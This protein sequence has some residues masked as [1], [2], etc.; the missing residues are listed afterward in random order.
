MENKTTAIREVPLA[1]V[2]DHICYKHCQFTKNMWMKE[3]QWILGTGAGK[4]IEADL[5]SEAQ[6]WK[7]IG[8]FCTTMSPPTLIR[9]WSIPWQ[10]VTWW[11]PATHH[12]HLTSHQ[13]FFYSLQRTS[14][15]RRKYL[16][17]NEYDMFKESLVQ[18]FE[19]HKNYAAVSAK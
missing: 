17:D 6:F 4:V 3:K 1:K 9:Q 16:D 2:K 15:K 19:W 5:K 14:L 8:P 11:R 18:S 7:G 10:T 12:I 13:Y